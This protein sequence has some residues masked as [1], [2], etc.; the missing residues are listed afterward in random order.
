MDRKAVEWQL[1][2]HL[3]NGFE[4]YAG[5]EGEK[6]RCKSVE[7]AMIEVDRCISVRNKQDTTNRLVTIRATQRLI[8]GGYL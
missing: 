2:R 8:G 6:I 7:D 1:D 5:F 4:L 3:I